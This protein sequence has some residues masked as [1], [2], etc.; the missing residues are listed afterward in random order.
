MD[1]VYILEEEELT[2]KS[3]AKLPFWL[4]EALASW[5]ATCLAPLHLCTFDFKEIWPRLNYNLPT[6][7]HS[8]HSGAKYQGNS[9][10]HRCKIRLLL[11]L[12]QSLRGQPH[13]L[14]RHA[15][16]IK[17]LQW[18]G[19]SNPRYPLA[20]KSP[21]PVQNRPGQE[22][23]G[24]A[25]YKEVQE[26]EGEEGE[27]PPPRQ[28]RRR[29]PEAELVPAEAAHTGMVTAKAEQ[30]AAAEQAGQAV[31]AGAGAVQHGLR[32]VSAAGGGLFSPEAQQC[33]F[34]LPCMPFLKQIRHEMFPL[35]LGHPR[36]AMTIA[37]P[38]STPLFFFTGTFAPTPTCCLPATAHW[39]IEE[40]Q[41]ARA[42]FAQGICDVAVQPAA[43][44]AHVV[45]GFGQGLKDVAHL[46]SLSTDVPSMGEIR[47]SAARTGARAAAPRVSE[48][49]E[50]EEPQK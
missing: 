16:E 37:W 15:Q 25:R 35:C 27:E 2:S 4:G 5:T 22:E 49:I 46:P 50:D 1:A 7:Q 39:G 18:D 13:T 11:A 3:Q 12:A 34:L 20:K 33:L 23:S 48:L 32:A 36:N 19:A 42:G 10:F 26:E 17:A 45:Q 9:Q 14:R 44:I 30:N 41:A 21:Y 28:S 40:M 47:Q 24:S 31:H 38:G 43:G 6:N 8:R 29:R